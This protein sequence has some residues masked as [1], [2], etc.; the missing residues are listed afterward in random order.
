VVGVG[1]FF[2][3]GIMIETVFINI[4][5]S[6]IYDNF[7][8]FFRSRETQLKKEKGNSSMRKKLSNIELR[9]IEF[10]GI[11]LSHQ[12]K[13][14][15]L[16]SA[17]I[18]LIS[19]V[20]TLAIICYQPPIVPV[21]EPDTL[22]V[23]LPEEPEPPPPPPPPPP[24]KIENITLIVTET[25]SKFDGDIK[26]KLEKVIELQDKV[27]VNITVYSSR[28]S[29]PFELRR[30]GRQKIGRYEISVEEIGHNYA[31]FRIERR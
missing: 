3:G 16:I 23:L 31:E 28:E 15:G 13:V 4:L 14:I 17:I 7:K 22:P 29:Q 6:L 11:K 1:G 30:N 24:P 19:G 12:T 9:K 5:S 25:S 21:P 26:I 27:W 20:V 10:M 8:I 2:L 18:V